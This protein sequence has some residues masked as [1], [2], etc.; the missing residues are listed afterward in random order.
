MQRAADLTLP[1]AWF[2]ESLREPDVNH[3]EGMIQGRSLANTLPSLCPA[4]ASRRLPILVSDY[5]S[6]RRGPHSTGGRAWDAGCPGVF[7]VQSAFTSC[8]VPVRHLF[9][10]EV[11][12]CMG[13]AG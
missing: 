13:A 11:E 9:G 1:V 8:E 12:T 3:P 6:A 10:G 4:P 2:Q 5:T 7:V